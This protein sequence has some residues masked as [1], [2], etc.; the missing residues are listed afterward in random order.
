MKRRFRLLFCLL[1]VLLT[2]CLAADRQTDMESCE[3]S[4]RE[5][6]LRVTPEAG[7]MDDRVRIVASGLTAGERVVVDTTLT[8]D[9]GIPWSARGVFRADAQGQVDS[10]RAFSVGGTY[11]GVEPYGLFWSML[12]VAAAGLSEWQRADFFTESAPRYP[13][14]ALDRPHTIRIAAYTAPH[15]VIGC[16]RIG[17][18]DFERRVQAAEVVVKPV[19][20]GNLRGKIYSPSGGNAAVGVIL[21][22]G[23]GGG[24][25]EMLAAMLASRG[26]QVFA[27]AW[28]NYDGRPD[29]GYNLPIEY[30]SEGIDW[31]RSHTGRDKI[32]FAG[33]S[34]GGMTALMVASTYPQHI[35]AVYAGVPSH[36]H[37]MGLTEDWSAAPTYTLGGEPIPYVDVSG[38]FQV[39]LP[40]MLS[41]A[42][43]STALPVRGSEMY[44]KYWNDPAL[45]SDAIIKVENIRAPIFIVAGED[46]GQW[47]SAIAGDRIVARLSGHA[48]P[49]EV[50]YRRAAGA[51]H[52]IGYPTFVSGDIN[53]FDF[54]D[55]LWLANGG[56]AR[57]DAAVNYRVFAE[58]IA[59]FKKNLD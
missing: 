9:N 39:S 21:V 22:S 1:S 54:G 52:M 3:A 36:V 40:E 46:D 18:V 17:T 15:A 43:K 35:G 7:L 11:D 34:Y 16:E 25:S 56:S 13:Q 55:G 10:T 2:A 49:H 23:S 47:P 8:D 20:E 4:L 14:L 30:F 53:N 31:F 37:M 29:G 28:Y 59:F 27:L 42:R 24:L 58:M 12:P 44:L 51:G 6:S 5:L 19:A 26:I 32:G 38:L 41:I 33:S 50:I 45:D 48:F 57:A